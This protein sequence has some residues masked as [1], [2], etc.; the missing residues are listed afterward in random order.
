MAAAERNGSWLPWLPRLWFSHHMPP[1]VLSLKKQ[2][3]GAPD[4]RQS[5]QHS[6]SGQ[7]DWPSVWHSA[8]TLSSGDRKKIM[9]L[10]VFS[11]KVG[12]QKGKDTCPSLF[13]KSFSFSHGNTASWAFILKDH[14][15][16]CSQGKFATPKC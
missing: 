2:A 12:I 9:D 14:S 16:S 7:Q 3:C 15:L 10:K 8:C 5:H 6:C 13:K 4:W 11:L 1:G